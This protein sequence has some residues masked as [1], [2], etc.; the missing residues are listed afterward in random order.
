MVKATAAETPAEK[1][2]DLAA[3]DRSL[4]ILDAPSWRPEPGEI[5]TA[6]LVSMRKGGETGAYDIYPILVFEA[7]PGYP[8]PSVFSHANGSQF[9]A[10]HAFHTIV[11][12]ALMELRPN[13]RNMPV[14]TIKYAGR[15]QFGDIIVDKDGNEVYVENRDKSDYASYTVLMGDGSDLAVD[16]FDWDTDLVIRERK[17]SK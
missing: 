11:K 6:S 16:G 15:V 8:F 3:R 4:A 10:F 12:Q 2:F 9:V 1:E 14:M 7:I 13:P 17:E 5:L